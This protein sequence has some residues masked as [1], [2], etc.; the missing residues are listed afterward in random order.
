MWTCT[1]HIWLILEKILWQTNPTLP[2]VSFSVDMI[3]KF[4]LHIYF[5]KDKSAA[6][7]HDRPLLQF[8]ATYSVLHS[9]THTCLPLAGFP[10]HIVFRCT[11]FLFS[12]P[13]CQSNS[14]LSFYPIFA[15]SFA[16]QYRVSVRRNNHTYPLSFGR[17][18]GAPAHQQ[19]FA[20]YLADIL[21]SPFVLGSSGLFRGLINISNAPAVPR[22]PGRAY[23]SPTPL[24]SEEHTLPHQLLPIQQDISQLIVA[25]SA[26]SCVT[27]CSH[28]DHFIDFPFLQPRSAA[29]RHFCSFIRVLFTKLRV[30]PQLRSSYLNLFFFY[31]A[32]RSRFGGALSVHPC[33]VVSSLFQYIVSVQSPC[34]RLEA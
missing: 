10:S 4:I 31:A 25:M 32:V 1:N 17:P 2:I 6:T 7:F 9:S 12:S 16:L 33:C 23:L 18:I 30:L 34:R 21:A 5:I 19:C 13:F 27:L 14:F 22:H 28:F 8:S 11:I 3:S 20:L 15:V 24:L 29:H 26:S